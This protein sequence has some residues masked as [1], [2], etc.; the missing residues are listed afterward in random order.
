MQIDPESGSRASSIK[1]RTGQP[2][3]RAG[4]VARAAQ[5]AGT[6]RRIGPAARISVDG[7]SGRSHHLAQSDSAAAR[8]G[9][10]SR[11]HHDVRPRLPHRSGR[12]PHHVDQSL[13]IADW[14]ARSQGTVETVHFAGVGEHRFVGL[15]L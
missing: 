13:G 8:H 12:H 3:E 10:C 11:L 1:T 6:A 15:V 7:Q 4:D 9:R 14:T 5:T 2:A